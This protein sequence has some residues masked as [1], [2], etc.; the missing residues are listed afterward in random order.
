MTESQKMPA[1]GDFLDYL[2][3]LRDARDATAGGRDTLRQTAKRTGIDPGSLSRIL[4]GERRLSPEMAHAL[5]CDLQLPP[6]LAE[7]LLI[8]V[9][10]SALQA[11]L[12]RLRTSAEVQYSLRTARQAG[13]STERLDHIFRQAV[14]A[15]YRA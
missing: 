7:R 14:S 5:L 13:I 9:I 2:T 12:Q 4:R 15:F 10:S 8:S 3:V 11:Q 1:D 6:E